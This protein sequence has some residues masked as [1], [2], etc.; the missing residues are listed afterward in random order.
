VLITSSLG[1]HTVRV[2]QA[3]DVRIEEI[4]VATGDGGRQAAR[5]RTSLQQLVFV[6][7]GG[8]HMRQQGSPLHVEADSWSLVDTGLCPLAVASGTHAIVLTLPALRLSGAHATVHA[9]CGGVARVLLDLAR[10]TVEV[11]AQL[12]EPARAEIGNS[13][14]EL[15][16]LLLRDDAGQQPRQSGRTILCERVK[17]FVRRHLHQSNLSIDYIARSFHCTKRYLH[18]AF[19]ESACS[20]NQFIWEQRLQRCAQDLANAEFG[21]RSVTEIAFSWG[22]SN[23]SHFSRTFRQRFG[24]PPSVYRSTLLAGGGAMEIAPDLRNHF[25]A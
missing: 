14:T 4:R 18:K 16:R 21:D 24:M 5:E 17:T 23:S 12:G 19:G 7:H 10:S 20:L 13:L 8:I 22:F 6:L 25:A 1:D 9:G 2:A 11:A 15:A 3:G